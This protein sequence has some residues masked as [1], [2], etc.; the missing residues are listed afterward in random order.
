MAGAAN[1]LDERRGTW[2]AFAT[3]HRWPIV[4][5]DLEAPDLAAA[6][7]ALAALASH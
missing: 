6:E 1:R 4:F 3:S 2:L 7:K 5:A